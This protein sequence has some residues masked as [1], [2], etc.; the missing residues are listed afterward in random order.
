MSGGAG[1][2]LLFPQTASHSLNLTHKYLYC[3]FIPTNGGYWA[4][5][6]DCVTSS[7][8]VVRMSVSNSFK[9]L[10]S[11]RAVL[12]LPYTFDCHGNGHVCGDVGVVTTTPTPNCSKWTILVFDLQSVFNEYFT[13]H[14]D[15]HYGYLKAVQ[16]TGDITVKGLYTS[17]VLLTPNTLPRPLTLPITKG[18]TFYDNYDY[19]IVPT[20]TIPIATP[21]PK[22]TPT[23]I[24]HQ[25]V[26]QGHSIQ[27]PSHTPVAKQQPMVSD[28]YVTNVV[29]TT[30]NEPQSDKV[31]S[32]WLL[33]L[34]LL[35]LLLLGQYA[36][37]A[38]LHW[39]RTL[40]PAGV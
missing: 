27:S 20:D 29:I 3:V 7:G 6:S 12:H 34:W 40:L 38:V 13:D 22:A 10:H 19:I 18:M 39:N 1:S 24:R 4:I 9:Q 11:D 16:L 30:H 37:V 5:H 36:E 33:L 28:N 17:N 25:A 32:L 35:S 31:Q 8:L 23:S 21:I 15:D 26:V 2:S 14:I